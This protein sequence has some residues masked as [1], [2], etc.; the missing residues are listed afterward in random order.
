M[1]STK[2]EEGRTCNADWTREAEASKAIG[3][4]VRPRKVSEKV[5]LQEAPQTQTRYWVSS[6]CPWVKEEEKRAKGGNEGREDQLGP[7]SG[8]QRGASRETLPLCPGH[9]QRDKTCINAPRR[10]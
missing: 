1:L 6:F 9:H 5:P 7:G 4:V 2:Q 3:V 10:T 8:G